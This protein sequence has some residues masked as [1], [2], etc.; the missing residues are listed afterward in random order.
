ME[1]NRPVENPLVSVILTSYNY[2]DFI[3]QAIDS[4]F[5]Q[6]YRPIELI[7]IDDGS[8]DCSVEVIEDKISDSPI[9]VVA[10]LQE[11]GGQANAWNNAFKKVAG[12]IVCF[13]DSDDYWKSVKV[14]RM[15]RL[16]Q[17]EPDGAVY[18]HQLENEEGEKKQRIL[19]AGDYYAIWIEKG[20]MNLATY[21]GLISPCVP[22]SGLAFRREV[23]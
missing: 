8:T 4:V 10:I 7:V 9:P 3:G 12:E 1:P 23:L 16:I 17:D 20:E 18:Q 2:A 11:N 19:G 14:E 5:E 6:T 21:Q 13:L 15:V 22:S